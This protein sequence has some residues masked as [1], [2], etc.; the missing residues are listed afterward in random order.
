MNYSQQNIKGKKN[1]MLDSSYK[2]R[3]RISGFL[4]YLRGL[5]LIAVLW[6]MVWQML[7]LVEDI[8]DSTEK[9]QSRELL[10]Q[11]DVSVLYDIEGNDIQKI[12][13]QDSNQA[14]V[15]LKQIPD[16]VQKAFVASEDIHFYEHHGIDVQEIL[17]NIYEGVFRA[18]VKTDMDTTIT[19][20]L[21][22][23]R[24]E[25]ETGG[26]GKSLYQLV[27]EQYL[28]FSLEDELKKDEI[29]EL[30][31]NTI[32]LGENILGV[33]SASR[34]YFN[35]DI[36][37]VTMSEAA[38][39]AA[40]VAE[41]VVY[42]PVTNQSENNIRRKTVLKSMLD[43]GAI[44]ESEY[45]DA[46]GDDVYLRIE[47]GKHKGQKKTEYSYYV[48][49]V[50]EQVLQ[51][52]KVQLGYTQT[53]AY[54]TL[55]RSGVKIYTCQDT[56]MQEICD[57]V[58]QESMKKTIQDRKKQTSFVL[59]EQGTGEIKAIVGGKD[60]KKDSSD[61]NYATKGKRQPGTLF[62]ILSTYTPALDTLGMSLG[63]VED[64][65]NYLLPDTLAPVARWREKQY[66]GLVTMREALRQSLSVPA[67]KILEKVTIQT[68]YEYLKRYGITTLVEQKAHFSS[69]ETE[70][71]TESDL[72]YTLALGKLTEGVTNL[73]MTAAYGI[74]ANQG[75]YKAP[76]FYNKVVDSQGKVL[77]ENTSDGKRIMK[78]STAWLLTCAM[79]DKENDLSG[80][81]KDKLK[82]IYVAGRYA[83]S[84]ENI[85]DWY[86]G[87][88]PYYTG[89]ICISGEENAQKSHGKQ[90]KVIWK[91][92]MER[93]HKQRKI[94]KGI[95]KKPA[96]IVEVEICTKCGNLGVKGLCS[97]AEGGSTVRR[98]YFAAGTQPV[99]NC[100]CH[101]RYLFCEDSKALA[102]EQ[103]PDEKTYSKVLLEKKETTETEDTPYTVAENVTKELCRIHG[104]DTKRK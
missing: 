52:M 5:L 46:L 36:G 84:S 48:D 75:V 29:L 21:L 9:I 42:N 22:Q 76:R 93:V 88:S 38:V 39:L 69:G 57:E 27:K 23:N 3:Y 56:G 100:T 34:Y 89:G 60:K 30:Y 66:K 85:D 78:E 91:K 68:S 26:E 44:S 10:S 24:M 74:I 65:A 8:M 61:S 25:Y 59:I 62:D 73:E 86:E 72:Q 1:R 55:Y 49:A 58:I 63:S 33:Q 45:E 41:P 97:K 32:N 37:D 14:Y 16:C 83:V 79:R 7:Q 31:L 17:Q 6:C 101:V 80:K 43:M 50:L 19:R 12:S 94:S 13:S 92:I 28:I 67:V 2:V 87:Y 90:A 70:N 103:C 47:N 18:K 96:D 54:N 51:D 35:K 102:S 4:R 95:Y 82:K 77:L 53:Q 11:G 15:S 71:S 99:K 20:Q 104:E 98:E 81:R 40:I 64:D